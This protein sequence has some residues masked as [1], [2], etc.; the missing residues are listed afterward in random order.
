MTNRRAIRAIKRIFQD[1]QDAVI[2]YLIQ[3][4]KFLMAHLPRRPKPTA[5]EKALL[6]RAAQAVDP[7]YLEKTF[8]LFTPSTLKRWQ[9]ELTRKK[10]DYSNLQKKR[11]RP[12]I[13]HELEELIVRLA[14]ENPT[15]GYQTL[16]GKLRLLGFT[17]NPETI[18][19][20]LKRNGFP[21]APERENL[22]TWKEFLDMRREDLAATDFFTWEVLTPFGLVTHYILFFIRHL[23]RKVHIAGVTTHPHERWMTQMAKNLTDPESGFLKE[24]MVL[25][26]DRDTKYTSHFDRTLNESRI[27]TIKLPPESPNLN[28]YAERLVRS[29]KE[30]CLSRTIITSEEQLRKA[31]KEYEIYYNQERPHQGIGNWVPSEYSKGQ[32]EVKPIGKIRRKQRLGGLLNVYFR[33]ENPPKPNH[34]NAENIA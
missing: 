20:I 32:K 16:V 4:I 15:D 17:A 1:S 11:G 8:N 7:I 28:A 6:A 9:R 2:Q 21:P 25:L 13:D 22:L 33:D 26:H 3:E 23:D 24:G 19:N 14:H 34:C 30:Q 31:L 18:Q 12:R 10:W 29:I 27:E 5:V